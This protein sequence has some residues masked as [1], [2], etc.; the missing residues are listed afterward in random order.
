MKDVY[1]HTLRYH[2]GR[3]NRTSKVMFSI[4][5]GPFRDEE[6]AWE[7]VRQ[8]GI[9][10]ATKLMTAPAGEHVQIPQ[11]PALK[12]KDKQLGGFL[13]IQTQPASFEPLQNPGD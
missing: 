13:P 8:A 3:G 9:T 11:H 5:Y 7:W 2:T 12:G 4:S 1:V 10:R 6:A